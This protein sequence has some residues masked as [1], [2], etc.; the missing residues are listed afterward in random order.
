MKLSEPLIM[1]LYSCW[2][3][4]DSQSLGLDLGMGTFMQRIDEPN[5]LIER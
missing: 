3:I 1:R 5:K 2:S 4:N